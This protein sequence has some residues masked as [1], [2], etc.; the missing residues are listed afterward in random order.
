MRSPNSPAVEA[1]R[2]TAHRLVERK[3]RFQISEVAGRN[4][5]WQLGLPCARHRDHAHQTVMHDL[6]RFER[7]HVHLHEQGAKVSQGSAELVSG[8]QSGNGAGSRQATY[9]R[10]DRTDTRNSTCDTSRGLHLGRAELSRRPDKKNAFAL[11]RESRRGDERSRNVGSNRR[12][13][14]PLR[15]E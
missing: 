11:A 5:S 10:R 1:M 9:S 4:A 2:V 13:R 14:E 15:S 8:A 7:G 6:P 3:P 12:V